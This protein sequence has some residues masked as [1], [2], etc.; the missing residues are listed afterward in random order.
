MS[1]TETTERKQPLPTWLCMVSPFMLGLTYVTMGLHIRLGLGHWPKPMVENYQTVAFRIHEGTFLVVMLFT[2][3]AAVPLWGVF[4]CFRR[5]RLSW[6]THIAQALTY[7][8]GWL[9]ILVAGKYDPTTF[10]DWFLD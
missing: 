4:L 1:T 2:V 10:T 5:L 3:F 9:V 8:L 6:R 7:S